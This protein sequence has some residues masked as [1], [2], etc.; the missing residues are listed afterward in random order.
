MVGAGRA[1]GIGIG[2]ASRHM[3]QLEGEISDSCFSSLGGQPSL[4]VSCSFSK[5]PHPGTGVQKETAQDSKPAARLPL[6]VLPHFGMSV[7]ACWLLCMGLHVCMSLYMCVCVLQC[8]FS[9]VCVCLCML[10]SVLSVHVSVHV[11]V[12]ADMCDVLISV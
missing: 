7:R 8:V 10:V 5:R 1:S 3:R 4:G 9:C 2:P 12:C 11:C 6:G